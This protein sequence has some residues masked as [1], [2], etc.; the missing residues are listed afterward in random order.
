MS[1]S[2]QRIKSVSVMLRMS[3]EE[4]AQLDQKAADVNKKLPGYLIACG[5]GR[6]TRSAMEHHIVQE[7]RILGEQQRRLF[8]EGGGQLHAQYAAVLAEVIAA[9]KRVGA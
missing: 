4:R 1:K 8:E 6:Q 2:E 3:P 9:I 7:L 5:L